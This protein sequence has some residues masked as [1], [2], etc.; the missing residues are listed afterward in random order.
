MLGTAV[1]CAVLVAS[2]CAFAIS[3]AAGRGRGHLLPAA[4]NATYA[5]C[6]L[7]ATTV[8][9]LAYAFQAHDFRIRYIQR[10]SD[11][12]MPWNYLVT[13]LWGGQDGSLLWWCFLTA[14]WT[15]LATRYLKNRY[16]ELAPWVLATLSSILAFFAMLM[17]FAANPFSTSAASVPLDGEGLNPLLQNY[18]MMIHP[19][20]LYMG[21]VGWCV[22]FAF[23][24][25]ALITGRLK[26][27]WI[28]AVRRW[29]VAAWTFLAFGN[30]L[31][32]LWSYEEL[33]WGG[34]WA[35][36]PVENAAFMPLLV[37][38]AYL[39][40]VMIQERRGMMKVWNVFLMCLTFIMTIFGTTLTRSG[41]IAS[42]H[43]FARSDIG[44]Y[45]VWYV[46]FLCVV[47]A[48]LIIWRLPLLK[49]QNQIDSMLSREFAFLLQNWVLLGMMLF[50]LIATTFPLISEWVRGETVTVGPSFYNK[51]MVPLGLVLMLLTGI[52]PL[53]SWRRATGK[54]LLRSFLKPTVGAFV[55]LGLHIVVGPSIG[56]P[57]FVRSDALYDTLTGEI[58]ASIYAAFPGLSI[59]MCTF[60]MGTILQEFWRGTAV[61]MKN[62]KE[63]VLVALVE[64]VSRAKRRYGGYIVHAALVS[65]YLGFTGAAYDV[66]K[67]AA[68][69]PGG[70]LEVGHYKLRYDGPR[71][72][73]DGNKTMLFADMTV[74]DGGE[75]VAKVSPA[76][77]KYRTHP[78]MPT[79]EVAIRSTLRDD[80]YVIMSQVNPETKLGTFRVIIRPFVSWIWIGGLMLLAGAFIAVSPSIKEL[81]ENVRS[82]EPRSRLIPRPAMATLLILLLAAL[83]L[84]GST[85][86]AQ[87]TSSLMAGNV[88]MN[89][90]EEKALFEKVLC[91]CGGCARLPLSSCVCEWAEGKREQI[92]LDIAGGK[93]SAEVVEDYGKQYG[94]KGLATPPDKGFDRALWAVPISG[95]VVAAGGIALLG[96]RWVK[97]NAEARATDVAPVADDAL[98][99]ELDAELRKRDEA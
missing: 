80:V 25:A 60:V 7:I 81:M 68:L 45:F 63:N 98:D 47:C 41:L 2:G 38:T 54:N 65:M 86:L 49:S 95:F 21:F 19:P 83:L 51:W 50:V 61:R 77:F 46:V 6:A 73:V 88:A 18:W 66:D 94:P 56:F 17:L 27:E 9:L 71:L 43:S 84:A 57:A 26:D 58:L 24:I 53:I 40:S 15:G 16:T 32:G 70:T 87:D 20:T 97:R 59:M 82:A 11:R 44:I 28:Y 33:G 30:L 90:P 29:A 22:P 78:D 8:C 76:K 23:C 67:E 14:L 37:G 52:G 92:R 48:G 36:D 62:A 34:Y 96:R 74:F 64:L 5:T 13:A 91:Q 93:T 39:H 75:A 10:Y 69:R 55:A 72:E 1:L 4:R 89:G 35:W 79:T 42:V 99:A 85:A 3:V 12:S 31:G